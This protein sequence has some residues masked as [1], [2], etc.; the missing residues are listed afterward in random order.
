MVR[1]SQPTHVPTSPTLKTDSCN[2][3]RSDVPEAWQAFGDDH[4][5]TR[6]DLLC[7]LNHEPWELSPSLLQ[8]AADCLRQAVQGRHWRESQVLLA[9]L[10]RSDLEP[11]FGAACQCGLGSIALEAANQNP[12][13][14]GATGSTA[15]L[16]R[17]FDA[18]LKGML[19][20]A[21]LAAAAGGATAVVEPHTHR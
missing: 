11:V 7:L 3:Y 16:G 21:V 8:V 14:L 9:I 1:V 5:L 6:D 19:E 4:C 13:E 17:V 20:E 15:R 2:Q 18:Q 10:I 12:D